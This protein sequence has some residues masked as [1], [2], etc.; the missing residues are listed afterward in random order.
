MFLE[1]AFNRTGSRLHEIEFKYF[2]KI[3]KF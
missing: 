1:T 3:G 2:D